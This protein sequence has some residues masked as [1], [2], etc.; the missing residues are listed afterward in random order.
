MVP[1]TWN[2]ITKYYNAKLDPTTVIKFSVLTL[3]EGQ[4]SARE[5]AA[6]IQ[7]VLYSILGQGCISL[8]P[9]DVTYDSEQNTIS[10]ILDNN[11]MTFYPLNRQHIE[12]HINEFIAPVDLDNLQSANSMLNTPYSST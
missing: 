2:T 8:T 3:T 1:H 9:Y 11:L 12:E 5:L 7:F 4:Y 10:V 6:H